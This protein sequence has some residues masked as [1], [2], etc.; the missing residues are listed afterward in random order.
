[1]NV[2]MQADFYFIISVSCFLYMTYNFLERFEWKVV[3][4][5]KNMTNFGAPN[6]TNQSDADNGRNETYHKLPAEARR[7][8]RKK[9][10]S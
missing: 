6:C 8:I 1:M 7:G 5:E 9:M 4:A 10:V 2:Q 3:K